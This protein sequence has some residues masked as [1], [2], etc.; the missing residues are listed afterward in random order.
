MTPQTLRKMATAAIAEHDEDGDGKLNLA[1]FK[2]LLSEV[3][4]REHFVVSL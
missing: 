4:L 3:A 2:S 1:E